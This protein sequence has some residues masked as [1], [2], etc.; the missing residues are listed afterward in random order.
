MR[1]VGAGDAMCKEYDLGRLIGRGQL[2][3]YMHEYIERLDWGYASAWYIFRYH[4]LYRY[5]DEAERRG[6]CLSRA[7]MY[8]AKAANA[9]RHMEGLTRAKRT[10]NT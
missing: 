7:G 10:I 8:L 3:E 5:A 9:H 6:L 4:E 1:K 2:L